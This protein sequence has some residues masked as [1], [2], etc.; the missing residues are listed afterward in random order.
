MWVFVQLYVTIFGAVW[1]DSALWS[2]KRGL[3]RTLLQLL[4]IAVMSV[5][6]LILPYVLVFIAALFVVGAGSLH[7][8]SVWKKIMK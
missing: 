8:Y 5:I 3:V 4:G 6:V 1:L 7:K 2:H